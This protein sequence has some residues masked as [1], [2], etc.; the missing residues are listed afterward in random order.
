MKQIRLRLMAVLLAGGC[1]MM[2][3]C[4][5]PG[6]E[7][8]SAAQKLGGSFTAE[9]TM[10]IDDMTAN[11]AI[12]RMGEGMWRVSFDEPSTLAGILLDFADGEVTASYKGLA[13]SVP[14]SA[15]PAKSVLSNLITVVDALSQEEKITGEEKDGGVAVSGELEGNPYILTLTQNGD[16]AGFEMD[17]MDAVL[18]FSDFQ[19][20]GAPVATGSTAA[21]G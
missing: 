5:K 6:G 13:F 15:M 17:N 21:A 19:S 9:M 1:A 2:T 16:L 12:S 4:A 7:D 18:T 3:G 10:S 20:G 14:Q 11:G 8:A